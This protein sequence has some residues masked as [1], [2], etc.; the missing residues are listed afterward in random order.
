MAELGKGKHLFFW[1]MLP[2][3]TLIAAL[4]FYTA[5]AWDLKNIAGA[6]ALVIFCLVL[7]LMI[8]DAQKFNWAARTLAAM[9]FLICAFYLGDMIYKGT[10]E[11]TLY[12]EGAR[13]ATS[14]PNAARA[15]VIFG[16][17]SLGY[18][19]FGNKIMNRFKKQ[20]S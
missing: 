1:I 20:G 15:F 6:A 13:S 5:H 17:P 10:Q 16:L 4:P 8:Y 14:V 18:A 12:P 7:L 3:L 11:Q 2:V 19:V 9:L